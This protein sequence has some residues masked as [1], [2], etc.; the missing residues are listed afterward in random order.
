[1]AD[2]KD[3]PYSIHGWHRGRP[4]A[5]KKRGG[6]EIN[7]TRCK[8]KTGADRGVSKKI[9]GILLPEGAGKAKPAHRSPGSSRRKEGKR[10]KNWT[11]KQQALKKHGDWQTGFSRHH[12]KKMKIR[13]EKAEL[14][15]TA[16]QKAA[17]KPI[18]QILGTCL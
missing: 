6:R 12:F 7:G 1:M 14:Q 5:L 3:N 18:F 10:W 8:F 16:L 9:H 13:A 2:F 17:R 11:L 4:A 15:F